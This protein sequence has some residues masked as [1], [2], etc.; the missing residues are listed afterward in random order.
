[1][2]K[3]TH[4]LS[5]ALVA[6]VFHLPVF[7]ALMASVLPDIDLLLEF[8]KRRNLLNAHRGITHHPIIPA[9]LLLVA[10]KLRPDSIL[11]YENLL[12][13]SLG[14]FSHLLLDMF[15]PLGIPMLFTYYPRLSFKLVRSG[16]FGETTVFIVLLLAFILTVK[17]ERIDMVDIIGKKNVSFFSSLLK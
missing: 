8:P 3:G 16:G 13:F 6:L 12:S 14:Y 15:T 1:M 9:F 2:T 5:G 10:V 17:I 7:P 11:L 4:L